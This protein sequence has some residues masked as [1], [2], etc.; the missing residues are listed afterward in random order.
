MR[1]V[2]LGYAIS[3]TLL[4]LAQMHPLQAWSTIIR[5][6]VPNLAEISRHL[7]I[8]S[9]ACGAIEAVLFERGSFLVV[10]RSDD[11]TDIFDDPFVDTNNLETRLMVT[12]TLPDN[13]PPAP[14]TSDELVPNRYEQVSQLIKTFQN[15]LKRHTQETF[16]ALHMDM[17]HF[18]IVL[19]NITT[20]SCVLILIGDTRIRKFLL[21]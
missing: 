13:L 10:A 21:L 11:Q 3:T 20:N 4:Y 2:C 6:L 9:R 17:E 16:K 5:T 1:T 8:L 19:D 7:T 12:Y 14:T 15:N 18:T